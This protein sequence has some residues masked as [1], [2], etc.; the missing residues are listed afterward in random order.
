MTWGGWTVVWAFNNPQNKYKRIKGWFNQTIDWQ[1]I[2]WRDPQNADFDY[3]PFEYDQ[4]LITRQSIDRINYN[5]IK[6]LKNS[7]I[8][9]VYSKLM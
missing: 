1:M 3:L 7:L 6:M 2:F 8:I 4:K 5:I 9:D